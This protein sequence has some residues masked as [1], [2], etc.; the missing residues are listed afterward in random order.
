MA[1][2]GILTLGLLIPMGIGPAAEHLAKAAVA[3]TSTTPAKHVTLILD[4]LSETV[5]TRAS[6]AE[7]LLAERGLSA[8]PQ[9]A[10]SVAP[11]APLRDGETVAFRAA[12]PVT[13]V[14]DGVPTALR[15]SA[16][17]VAALLR[18][19]GVAYD[20]HDRISPAP[21]TP[22]AGQAVVQVDHVASW[23]ETVRRPI[24][25]PVIRRFAFSLTPGQTAV[26]APGR[27]G[28][29]ELRYTVSRASGRTVRRSLLVAR[30]LR[31]P[32]AKI[33][34]EGVGEYTA[35][36][37]IAERG[38]V[39]TLRLADSA[40]AMV[41]TAYTANCSGCSG[42]TATGRRA[43]RGIV[44]VDPRVIPLGTKLF[45]PGYGRAVAGDTG[46]AIRGRRIDL[47]FESDADAFRFGRRAITVYLIK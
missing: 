18:A 33:V 31:T 28:L 46:G 39:G 10:L 19:Q 20:R 34:A 9:D 7:D 32:Q 45:I 13:V 2:T 38:I 30:V 1:A 5:E 12:A 8:T 15:S 17:T 14:V 11:A 36:S 3:M 41:A 27:P 23:T 47:G 42:T 40:L 22:L 6:D 21:A 44:A 25:P 29:Q 24:A 4:G 16:P 35:L 26:V 43:G 37:E